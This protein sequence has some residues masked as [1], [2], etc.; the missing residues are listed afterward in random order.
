MCLLCYC[1]LDYDY[2]PSI[3]V[4]MKKRMLFVLLFSFAAMGPI[5]VVRGA[6]PGAAALITSTTRDGSND[7]NFLLGKWHY[8]I[9]QLK[10]RLKNS[11][12]WY[13]C[14]ATGEM[15]PIWGGLYGGSGNREDTIWRCPNRTIYGITVRMYSAQTHQWSIWWG[16]RD[17]GL[18]PPP[19]VGHFNAHGFGEF[20]ADDTWKGTPVIV[21]FRWTA[22][23]AHFEQAFSS[24]HGKTWETNVISDQTHK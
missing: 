15:R 8:H 20:F 16:L 12:D 21:R 18:I 4:I 14:T 9:R 22:Q 24:D 7:F 6:E 11:H 13:D 2:R 5:A 17:R 3:I 23:G 19:Q 1:H 10:E